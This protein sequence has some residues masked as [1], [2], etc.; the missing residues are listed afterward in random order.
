MRPAS[1]R[2]SLFVLIINPMHSS[3]NA[4]GIVSFFDGDRKKP[5]YLSALLECGKGH[6]GKGSLLMITDFLSFKWAPVAS[7]CSCRVVTTASTRSVVRMSAVSSQ[8]AWTWTPCNSNSTRRG[9]MVMKRRGAMGSPC[10]M[11]DGELC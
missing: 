3:T 8:C 6:S 7:W 9:L 11:P 1:D 4:G 5:R 2:G 10:R